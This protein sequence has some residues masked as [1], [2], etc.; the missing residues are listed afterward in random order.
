MGRRK[1]WEPEP[2]LKERG[3]RG[4]ST[5]CGVERGDGISLERNP[6]VGVGGRPPLGRSKRKGGGLL[7]AECWR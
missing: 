7:V 5:W 6:T 4:V 1:V 3:V 2:G